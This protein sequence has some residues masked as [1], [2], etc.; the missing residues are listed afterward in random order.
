ML[1]SINCAYILPCLSNA[2]LAKA[3]YS[4]LLLKLLVKVWL[5]CV[6]IQVIFAYAMAR[7][8]LHSKNLFFL[9]QDWRSFPCFLQLFFS[10]LTETITNTF[11]NVN[12]V[13]YSYFYVRHWCCEQQRMTE[14]N[15]H[16]RKR[17]MEAKPQRKHE[18]ENEN[19]SKY[20]SNTLSNFINM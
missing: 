10:S 16:H 5:K 17:D 14:W 13:T 11:F 9:L 3:W 2:T 12:S 4:D 1:N 15:G 7:Q 8:K 19:Y 6:N 20:F 18:V